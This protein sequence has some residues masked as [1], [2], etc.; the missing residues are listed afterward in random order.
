MARKKKDN[1]AEIGFEQQ[2]W[3]AADKLRGNIDASE[4]KN[5]VLGLIF[6]KYISDKFDQRHQ[7][8]V[9]EGE[10]FE[11]DRD[12][13]TA[14]NIFFVP[15]SARWKTIAAA[16]HTPEVGKVI[17]EAMRQ[18]EAENDKLKNILPRSWTSAAWARSWTSS[19]TCRWRRRATRATSWDAPTSTASPSSQRQRARTRASS[20]RPHVS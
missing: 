5:V 8:L 7:E 19:P 11:E 15:E 18:I 1:T 9:D 14:E 3:S 6:L 2:I 17:D 4:Y 13:Y 12:E 20:T 16:A 10:G